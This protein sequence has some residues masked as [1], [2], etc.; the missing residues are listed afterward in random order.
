MCWNPDPDTGIGRWT[1]DEIRAAIR[2]GVARGKGV[3]T[4]AMPYYRYAGMSDRDV[5]DLI[6]YLR[7]LPSVRRPNRAHEGVLP[8][9]RLAYR[10]WRF[11]FVASSSAS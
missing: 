7:A 4:P 11:L 5:G 10:A 3:E 8:C 6:A 9:A 1:D 2:E